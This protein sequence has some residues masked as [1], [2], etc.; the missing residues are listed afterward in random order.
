MLMIRTRVITFST[1]SSKFILCMVAITV[2]YFLCHVLQNAIGC[3]SVAPTP[4]PQRPLEATPHRR[5]RSLLRH[6]VRRRRRS[7][8]PLRRS[9][10]PNHLRRCRPGCLHRGPDH[11]R[12]RSRRPMSSLRPRFPSR[13]RRPRL[14]PERSSTEAVTSRPPA[15]TPRASPAASPEARSCCSCSAAAWA[16]TTTRAGSCARGCNITSPT[17]IR[18]VH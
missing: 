4:F 13:P 12:P 10:H 5:P 18:R 8:R 17:R 2:A 1:F 16:Y 11:R 6:P 3:P 7:C 15:M 9:C 14:K